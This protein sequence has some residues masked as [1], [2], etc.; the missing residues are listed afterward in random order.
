MTNV[1]GFVVHI[2]ITISDNT[3][4]DIE[5]SR[6]NDVMSGTVH[7]GVEVRRMDSEMSELVERPWL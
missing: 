6:I 4:K 2:I 3:E 1:A 7:T 5:D